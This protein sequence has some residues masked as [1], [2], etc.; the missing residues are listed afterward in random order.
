MRIGY[1]NLN[2][3]SIDYE[4]TGPENT[5]IRAHTGSGD[6]NVEGLKANID[7][8]SGSGDLRLARLTGELSFQTGS[9]NVRRHQ[10]SVPAKIKACSGDIE[11]AERG[12]GDVNIRTESGN[13]TANGINSVFHTQ[14]C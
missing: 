9:G 7:L 11:I 6:Q 1:V 3:I 12:A 4:S 5:A 13:I 10:L 8:E 14:P 2:D